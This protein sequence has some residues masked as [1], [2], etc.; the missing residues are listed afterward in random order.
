MPCSITT[1][2]YN[3]IMRSSTSRPR[4]TLGFYYRLKDRHTAP[5]SGLLHNESC[6]ENPIGTAPKHSRSAP[7]LLRLRAQLKVDAVRTALRH[8]I[9][10]YRMCQRASLSSITAPRPFDVI[11]RHA[12]QQLRAEKRWALAHDGWGVPRRITTGVDMITPRR[13]SSRAIRHRLQRS[14]SRSVL[15]SLQLFRGCASTHGRNGG[16]G[17]RPTR[18]DV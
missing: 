7:D 2:L 17:Q 1:V 6:R 4:P 12:K 15:I 3:A 13:A 11:A 18:T 10:W 16:G 9:L 8:G 5:V 14:K